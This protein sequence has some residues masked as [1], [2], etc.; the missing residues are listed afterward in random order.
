MRATQVLLEKYEEIRSSGLCGS[1]IS[2]SS[3]GQPFPDSP[4]T[5][6]Q[7]YLELRQE[8]DRALGLAAVV[9]PVRGSALDRAGTGVA[10]AVGS[11]SVSSAVPSG[12]VLANNVGSSLHGLSIASGG[13]AVIHGQQDQ[14]ALA[15]RPTSILVVDD[16]HISCK[17]AKRALAQLNFHAE[18]RV[19]G[20]TE[21]KKKKIKRKKNRTGFVSKTHTV[22][23]G[24]IYDTTLLV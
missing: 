12:P 14:P 18:V 1:S 5:D 4:P 2:T 23:P 6:R 16:S 21:R 15:S 7:L 3:L 8:L 10:G 11:A 22:V 20:T 17:L 24:T 13:D 19:I 9:P